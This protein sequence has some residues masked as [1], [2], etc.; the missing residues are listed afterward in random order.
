MTQIT[1]SN[2]ITNPPST[3]ADTIT[4]SLLDQ[5]GNVKDQN[6]MISIRLTPAVLS[7]KTNYLDINSS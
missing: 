3:Y 5:S 4:I 1:I 2:G 7:S 6:N